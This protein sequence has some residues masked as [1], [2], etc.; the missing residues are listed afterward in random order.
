MPP[1]PQS[2]FTA[3]NLW[4][5]LVSTRKEEVVEALR[6]CAR[7]KPLFNARLKIR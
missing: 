1:Y 6:A 3:L 4:L 5:N 7:R 2:F